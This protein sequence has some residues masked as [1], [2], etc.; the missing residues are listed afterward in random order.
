M[1]N[2]NEL[3]GDIFDEKKEK[4]KILYRMMFPKAA[5][6]HKFIRA[7]LT[8]N[9]EDLFIN[10]AH[11]QSSK[12]MLIIEDKQHY[13]LDGNKWAPINVLS[14]DAVDAT[15]CICVQVDESLSKKVANSMWTS[16]LQHLCRIAYP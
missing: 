6:M 12:V 1:Q 7:I 13:F 5:T 3:P 4:E 2:E 14:N 11:L 15:D 8:Q 10:P 16:F 9:V